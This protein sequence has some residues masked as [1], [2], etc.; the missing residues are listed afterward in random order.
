MRLSYLFVLLLASAGVA[1]AHSQYLNS[2]PNSN[3]YNC[4]TCHYQGKFKNDFAANNHQWNYALAVKD[5]DGDGATNGVELQDPQ[6]NWRPGQPNPHINGWSTY[7]PD[8]PSSVPPY[9]P[10]EP[11]SWGRVKALYK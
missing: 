2:I 8:N 5:S 1:S 6:G 9:A 4:N 10:V 7:N 11:G 3:V